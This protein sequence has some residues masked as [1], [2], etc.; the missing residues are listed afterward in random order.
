MEN[1]D[2]IKNLKDERDYL[3]SQ[4]Y[5]SRDVERRLRKNLNSKLI[6]VI[7]G[8]RRAG[9]STVAINILS[10]YKDFFYLNFDS[11]IL[12]KIEDKF[13]FI[14]E[15]T[16]LFKNG[17]IIFIDEV[18]NLDNF[19]ILVNQLQR[20]GYNVVI[21]GS[22]ANLLSRELS[23]HLTGRYIETEV[24]P[25]SYTE[26]LEVH[27]N[28][29]FLDYLK[30]GGF[31]EQ[32]ISK[33]KLVEYI[34][35]LFESIILKDIVTRYA[36]RNS[37][38]LLKLSKYLISNPAQLSNFSRLKKKLDI[39]SVNTVIDHYSYLKEAYLIN[40]L[41]YFSYKTSEIIRSDFKTYLI[42]TGVV[43]S[44]LLSFDLNMGYLLE[45]SIFLE[46]IRWGYR[47]N[48][49]LFMLKDKDN[50]ECD[51]F[52]NKDKKILIQVSISIKDNNTRE[53]EFR[54]ITNSEIPFDKAFVV[55]LD[56]TENNLSTNEI[57]VIGVQE[58]LQKNILL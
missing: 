42:D 35:T 26:S 1:A 21:T 47:P 29:K 5:Y 46:L 43:S 14:K 34:E 39:G 19:E 16:K 41:N 3:I 36:I 28:L 37:R 13:S 31:P 57:E 22:N 17:K 4:K 12:L 30:I 56:D 33:G 53:R 40:T 51:F 38:D 52:I 2:I 7:T 15:N 32:L 50:Y 25:F 20:N 11:E 10:K 6:K 8:P 49:E 55:V 44:N 23:T 45:N 9:K 54:G 18:Q 24:L 27:P 48:I 58:F